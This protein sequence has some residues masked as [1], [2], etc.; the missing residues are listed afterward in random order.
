MGRAKFQIL[1]T[2]S[3]LCRRRI[4]HIAKLH[5]ASSRKSPTNSSFTL[6]EELLCANNRLWFWAF[7]EEEPILSILYL[8]T[9]ILNPSGH[10]GSIL[11]YTSVRLS[12]WYVR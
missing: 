10:L 7:V 8:F 9:Q 11:R 5:F 3:V 1:W 6:V 2:R 12:V 4:F